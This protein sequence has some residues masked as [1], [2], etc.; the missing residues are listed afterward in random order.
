MNIGCCVRLSDI[1]S[2]KI[3]NDFDFIEVKFQELPQIAALNGLPEIYAI[4]NVYPREK[5]IFDENIEDTYKYF[6]NVFE[7]SKN[8]GVKLITFGSGKARIFKDS[9]NITSN[10]K[11]WC[12]ILQYLDMKSVETGIKITL[13]PLKTEETNFVKTVGDASYYIDLLQLQS[14]GVTLDSHHFYEEVDSLSSVKENVAKIAH[15]HTAADEKRTY[16]L[17]VPLKAGQLL[18]ELVSSGYKQNVSIEVD[19]RE[20]LINDTNCL[21]NL[22]EIYG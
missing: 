10:F 14:V 9:Q 8:H 16:P 12:Q 21:S 2:F 5:N 6:D 18:E 7:T 1:G 17:S 4:N 13:E 20:E 3:I 11:T 22:R 19:W 15:F